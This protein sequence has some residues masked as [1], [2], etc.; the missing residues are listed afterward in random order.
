[1]IAGMNWYDEFI[2]AGAR[3]VVKVLRE[4]GIN[5]E[6]SC[7]HNMTIQCGYVIDGQL[8][9][10]HNLLFNHFT[11]TGEKVTYTVTITHKV[12]NGYTLSTFVEIKLD[13]R[14]PVPK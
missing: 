3:D 4:N 2:E 8:M 11:A 12:C 6:C 13:N 10:I 1:M 9:D 7:H 5:T 14:K